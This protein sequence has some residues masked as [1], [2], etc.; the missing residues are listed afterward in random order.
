MLIFKLLK[1][2]KEKESAFICELLLKAS[3]LYEV[4]LYL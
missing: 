3:V 1:I 2:K 4:S